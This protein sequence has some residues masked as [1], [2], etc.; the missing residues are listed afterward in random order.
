MEPS[1]PP[2]MSKREKSEDGEQSLIFI[3]CDIFANNPLNYKYLGKVL[4]LI[5]C[6]ILQL[7]PYK[8]RYLIISFKFF[9]VMTFIRVRYLQISL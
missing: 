4:S 5:F 3:L 1:V 9:L 6:N 2:L 7:N 8:Y